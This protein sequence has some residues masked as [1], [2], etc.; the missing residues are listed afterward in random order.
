[1]TYFFTRI[2]VNALAFAM[3]V[4][5]TWNIEINPVLTPPEKALYVLATG[6]VLAIAHWLL[7][8]IIMLFVGGLVLW[9]FGLL[10]V[11]V[12]ALVLFVS[13]IGF[14]ADDDGDRLLLV[15]SSASILRLLF[16]ATV[17]TVLLF[18]LEG[19][20][21]LDSPLKDRPNSRRRYWR[22]LNRLTIGGRNFLAENLRFAMSL[23]TL[24]QYM[25]D[26]IFDNSPFAPIRH[27]FQH[28]VYLRRKPL[29]RE[30]TPATVRYMLQDL[31]P[32]FVKLGQIVSSRSEQLPPQWRSELAQLQSEV[33]PFQSAV[34]LRFIEMELGRPISEVFAE[35][36]EKPLAAASTAQVHRA[37]LHN[38]DQVVVKVQRPDIDVTVRADL[39][40][41]RDLTKLAEQRLE[42]ARKSDLHAI[43]NEY[44]ANILLELDYTNEA[45]NGR[46]LAENM[47]LFPTIHVPEVCT[48][49]STAR[50]MT[51]EFV[52][53]VKITN[54]EALDA[55][56]LD[57]SELAQTFVRAMV[58]QIIYDGF[59]H[60]DPHPGNVLVDTETGTIIFLDMGMMGTLTSDKRL[61]L[62]DLILSLSERDGR[63]CARTV[64][65]LTVRSGPV[66]E[67]KFMQ[68]AERLL[69]RFTAFPDVPLSVGG[70][71]TS[72]L[73]ALARAGL[74]MD[75][76]LTLALKAMIQA[77]ETAHSLDPNLPL[78]DAAMDATRDLFVATFDPDKILN[79]LRT[80]ALRTAKQAVRSIPSIEEA[81]AG[82][83]SQF[84]RGKFV[85]HLDG[86][87]LTKQIAEID[88]TIT[89]NSRRLALALLVV[90]LLIGGGIAS[91]VPSTLF[92]QLAQLAYLIF[93]GAA[94]CAAAV[95]VRSLWRWLRGKE[96]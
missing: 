72:V 30:S 90:G 79:S 5:L 21:G 42:W 76:D 94:V 14:F 70:A 20:T 57:R 15:S 50:V 77:E 74:R 54:V 86:T 12:N 45:F 18:F 46:L 67:E 87:D 69:K 19:V 7:T 64:L 60:G 1:M 91:S 33:A 80:Q 44:A 38:G 56:G 71:M 39:N 22:T 51:Q 48:D 8:P 31:G 27:L 52:R 68:D 95:I 13:A 55:A 41:M 53:G 25:R 28:I 32:T 3:M 62:A 58:K 37:R 88:A 85:V 34:A 29:I 78:V 75:P 47:R 84:Q 35:F 83:L 96:V 6:T 11:G 93:V 92:P 16:A 2:F 63:E 66:D 4:G 23:D 17:L 49:L 40:I 26:I 9:S 73:D 59:F 36:D 65:R 82:W 10:M 24:G 43:M 81:L 89:R 61:A